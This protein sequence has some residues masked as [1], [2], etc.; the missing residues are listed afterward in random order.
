M[1]TLAGAALAQDRDA[2]GGKLALV[3]PF[4]AA[5]MALAADLE[6]DLIDRGRRLQARIAATLGRS[7]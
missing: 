7:A 1:G 2:G 5:A 3:D 6:R 4:H